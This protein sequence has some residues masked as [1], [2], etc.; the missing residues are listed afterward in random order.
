M[1]ICKN[2]T[3][4]DPTSFGID[5]GKHFKTEFGSNVEAKMSWKICHE[6]TWSSRLFA[7]TNYDHVQGDWE[8]TFDF[9]INKY[10]STRLYAHLRFDNS[11]SK[12][13][14]WKYWQFNEIL[15]FGFSY[16]FSM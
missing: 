9:T 5:E 10:L 1:N 12:D 13:P 3:K 2:N 14:D 16:K 7:F 6:V 4:V 15:S 8:N 11:V